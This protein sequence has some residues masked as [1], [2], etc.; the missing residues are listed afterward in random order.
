MGVNKEKGEGAWGRGGGRGRMTGGRGAGGG[1]WEA[2]YA[3]GSCC[4]RVE[5]IFQEKRLVSCLR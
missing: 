5:V 2:L 1:E 4:G 3:C